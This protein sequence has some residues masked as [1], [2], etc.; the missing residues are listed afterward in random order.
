[1]DDAGSRGLGTAEAE[2]PTIPHFQRGLPAEARARQGGWLLLASLGVFFLGSLLT[3]MLAVAGQAQADRL[4]RIRLPW[5]LL[6]STVCL[7][8]V[9]YGVQV[10][11]MA[12][13]RDRFA[14]AQRGLRLAIV[15]SLLFLGIQALAISR[16]LLAAD[17]LAARNVAAMAVTLAVLH[18]LHVLGGVIALAFVER[19]VRTG[20]YD[21]ERH[22]AVDFTAL[23]WH[24]LDVVWICLIV[25]FWLTTGGFAWV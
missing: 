18:G 3:Y 10:A 17:L 5:D 21:H 15:L 7:L 24:F 1:V 23:Y 14:T 20:R 9:S 4:A 13:R 12:I 22:W 16:F 11:A 19:G 2:R 6:L 25:C 8:F